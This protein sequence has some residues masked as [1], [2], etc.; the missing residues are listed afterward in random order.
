[1]LIAY[2]TQWLLSYSS[3]K[4]AT[5]RGRGEMPWA[6]MF[7]RAMGANPIRISTKMICNISGARTFCSWTDTLAGSGAAMGAR[8]MNLSLPR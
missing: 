3:K 4:A 8:L 5:V 7:T 1:M 6:R 2:L